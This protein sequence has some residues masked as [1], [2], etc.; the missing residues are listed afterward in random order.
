MY[1]EIYMF[2]NIITMPRKVIVG[3]FFLADLV[4]GDL[5]DT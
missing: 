4:L 5:T 3:Y 1:C 2:F